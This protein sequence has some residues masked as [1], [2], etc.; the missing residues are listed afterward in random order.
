MRYYL[1]VLLAVVL[2]IIPW[3]AFNYPNE[4]QSIVGAAGELGLQL[5]DVLW[6]HNPKSVSDIQSRYNSNVTLRGFPKPL[7]QKVR[8]LLV[9]GHEPSYGGAEF[10]SLKERDM[11]VELAD[12]LRRFLASSDRYEV[13]VTRNTEGWYP[14][15]DEYF[16]NGWD[17]IIAWMRSHK[18]EI[19]SLSRLGEYKPPARAVYHNSVPDNVAL[20]L[21]GIG[22]WANEN[23][24]DIVIHIHFNDYPG[25][26]QA[27]G[28]YSGFAI[29]VPSDEYANSST[30]RVLADAVFNRLKKYNAVSDLPGESS[31]IVPDEDLIAIGAYNSVDA[32]SM[33]IEYGY[34]Y[35]PQFMNDAVRGAAISDLAYQT[36]L[37]L[38]DFLGSQAAVP[39]TAAGVSWLPDTVVVPHTWAAPMS[40]TA[41][42]PADVFA[43]QTALTQDGDYPPENRSKHDCPRTGKIGPCTKAALE[44]FQEKRGISGEEGRA[45]AETLR[46]LNNLY[47]AKTL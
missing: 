8:I 7:G 14:I 47:S 18:A 13:F 39:Q 21:Y 25:H 11:V 19:T 43:L 44:A 41:A 31:G 32:A 33:L 45:G 5:A 26:G 12:D 22:K 40:E 3:F 27:P 2:L 15:F 20:R 29:Y 10:G 34:I 23:D 36:Y 46:E 9:P 6:T 1:S 42:D 16:K 28:K 17:D 35:E 38:Q 37:G 30:T 24:I 4:A